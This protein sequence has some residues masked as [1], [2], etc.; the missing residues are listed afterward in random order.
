[1]PLKKITKEEI[2]KISLGVFRKNGYHHTAMSDLAKACNL[3]KGSFYHYFD[4]KELLMHA[5][6]KDTMANLEAKVYPISQSETPARERMELLL[7]TF[8]KAVLMQEGGCIIGNTTMETAH[9]VA[10]FRPTLKNIFDGLIASLKHIYTDK[11]S[12]ET[13]QRL[14]E[15]TV[16]EFEGAVML[17]KIY[18][19][20]QYFKD[21]YNR[22]ISRL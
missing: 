1:M 18:G 14:A 12:A 2:L 19:G 7:K 16:M 3:Q 21:C 17:T 4:S 11:F 20:D 15:Q 9:T 13:S 22:V 10:E 8:S 6:L 5:I